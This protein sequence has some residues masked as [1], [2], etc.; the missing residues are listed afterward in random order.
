MAI[1]LQ[2]TVVEHAAR[3]LHLS[4]CTDGTRESGIRDRRHRLSPGSIESGVALMS[5]SAGT[6]RQS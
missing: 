4:L 6:Y 3:Q 2:C 5:P 1:T